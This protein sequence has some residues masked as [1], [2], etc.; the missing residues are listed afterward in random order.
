ML[1]KLRYVY[2]PVEPLEKA[3]TAKKKYHAGEYRT[4]YN[5]KPIKNLFAI[6]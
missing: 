5:D 6:K 2:T 4:F 3:I 1:R